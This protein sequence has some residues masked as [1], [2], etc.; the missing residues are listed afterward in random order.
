MESSVRVLSACVDLASSARS[1]SWSCLRSSTCGACASATPV[2]TIA[3]T[4]QRNVPSFPGFMIPPLVARMRQTILP[5]CIQAGTLGARRSRSRVVVPAACGLPAAGAVR[6]RVVAPSG[7]RCVARRPR[8]QSRRPRHPGR[9]DPGRRIPHR[10]ARAGADVAGVL[11]AVS[12]SDG[13]VR[14]RSTSCSSTSS[15]TR[16]TGCSTGIAC[17]GRC[18]SATTRRGR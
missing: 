12:R 4:A 8:P 18:T 16:S 11:P 9:R 2:A 10:D 17:C 1:A 13:G 6:A 3:A 14:S 7:C 5:L 15:T